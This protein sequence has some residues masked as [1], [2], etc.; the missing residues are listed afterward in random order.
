[1]RASGLPALLVALCVRYAGAQFEQMFQQMFGDNVQFE[2]QGGGGGGP[3]V[4]QEPSEE[5]RWLK[6]TRW[7]W[8]E[9]R[10]VEFDPS[11][12]VEVSFLPLPLSRERG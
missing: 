1:M 4:P 11:G 7:N 5:F 10:E 12:G 9:W 2:V 8:N 6:G 3:A